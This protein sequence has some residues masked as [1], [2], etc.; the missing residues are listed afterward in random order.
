MSIHS[1]NHNLPI[2]IIITAG[3]HLI[4]VFGEHN[5]SGTDTASVCIDNT[6]INKVRPSSTNAKIW[7]EARCISECV[8]PSEQL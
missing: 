7:G 5:P 8:T 1:S 4:V 3:M 6:S 2:V